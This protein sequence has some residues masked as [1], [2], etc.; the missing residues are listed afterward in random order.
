MTC[1]LSIVTLLPR[2]ERYKLLESN[3]NWFPSDLSPHT[4][5]VFI[6]KNLPEHRLFWQQGCVVCTLVFFLYPFLHP[7]FTLHACTIVLWR[8]MIYDYDF[9]TWCTKTL[10]PT[11]CLCI[12]KN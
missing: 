10:Q 2:S 12:Q 6:I 11:L 5:S 7:C 9:G 1:L 8:G 3:S 4:Q